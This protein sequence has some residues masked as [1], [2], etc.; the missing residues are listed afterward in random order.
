MSVCIL[1]AVVYAD[2]CV[3]YFCDATVKLIKFTMHLSLFCIYCE[4]SFP[5]IKPMDRFFF[6]I[7]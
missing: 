6:Q 1:L 7:E 3:S 4:D 5:P 2:F